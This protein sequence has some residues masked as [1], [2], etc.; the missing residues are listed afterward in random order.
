MQGNR[1]IWDDRDDGRDRDGRERDRR[2]RDWDWDWRDYG[3]TWDWERYWDVRCQRLQRQ[4]WDRDRDFRDRRD[5]EDR[6]FRDR[7]RDRLWSHA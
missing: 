3:D 6:D 4:Q 7:S 5:N 2:D 1:R